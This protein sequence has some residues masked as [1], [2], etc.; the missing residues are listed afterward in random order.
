MGL[1]NI[2]G[3]TSMVAGQPED[4]T[5][6]V[7]NFQAIQAILNGGIDDV[8]IRPTAAINPNKLAGYPTDSSKVLRGDGSWATPLMPP[9]TVAQFKAL[10]PVDGMTVAVQIADGICW[11]FRYN[12]G[13][14][15]GNKWEFI[16]GNPLQ[17]Y[18]DANE[19]ITASGAAQDAATAGPQ[20]IVPIGGTYVVEWSFNFQAG[21][22]AAAYFGHVFVGN[23]GTSPADGINGGPP[24]ASGATLTFLTVEVNVPYNV[25]GTFVKLQYGANSGLTTPSVRLRRISVW[26]RRVTQ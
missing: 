11:T 4:I 19:T 6:V 15:L 13:S 7:A 24:P 1:Y 8:N 25:S 9:L 22:S 23:G 14:G 16:G 17:S 2:V 18:I 20:V 3:A 10:T 21:G 12:A 5:Q 26:P